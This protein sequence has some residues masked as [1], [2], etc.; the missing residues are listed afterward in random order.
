VNPPV[1]CPADTFSSIV[2]NSDGSVSSVTAWDGTPASTTL[3]EQLSI[4][5]M[6]AGLLLN[7]EY[8]ISTGNKLIEYEGTACELVYTYTP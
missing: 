4:G 2:I 8:D 7:N 6:P 5:D 1:Q 3:V